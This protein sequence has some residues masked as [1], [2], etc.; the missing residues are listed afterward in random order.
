MQNAECQ[1]VFLTAMT[2][3]AIDACLTKIAQLMDRYREIPNLSTAWLDKI[4]IEHVS[5]GND[6]SPPAPGFHY[7]YAGT[8]YQVSFP[9][10]LFYNPDLLKVS[11]QLYNFSKRRSLDVD[12]VI[13][14]EAGQ[15]SLGSAALVLRSLSPTGRIIIAG[16]SEQLA[17]ILTAQYPRLKRRLFGSILDCLMDLSEHS[18]EDEDVDSTHVTRPGS[19][20]ELS[21]ISSSQMSTIIQLT[22][23]FRRVFT[24]DLLQSRTD[25]LIT[26][27]GADSIQIWANLFRRYIQEHSSHKKCKLAKLLHG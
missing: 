20:T 14:D 23:N 16:D 1:M 21:E 25:K 6:H 5:K 9:I 22:E 13:I 3:A 4:K 18:P 19:P 26:I 17:P 8:V 7:V 15:L 12:C 11:W 2:H 10:Y 27:N 24:Y